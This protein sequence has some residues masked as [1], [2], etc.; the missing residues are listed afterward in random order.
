MS[1]ML[2]PMT[3]RLYLKKQKHDLLIL[4]FVEADRVPWHA[5]EY[6][7]RWEIINQIN[8]QLPWP[9]LHWGGNSHIISK[10]SWH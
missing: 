8:H 10:D 2:I 3:N 7:P 4:L 6:K 5:I 1:L 9:R